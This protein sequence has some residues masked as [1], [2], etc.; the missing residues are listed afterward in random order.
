MIV[1]ITSLAYTPLASVPSTRTW[2]SFGL[3]MA[4][5]CVA[6]TSRTCVDQV[7]ADQQLCLT[8]WQ[9]ADRVGV[10]DLVEQRACHENPSSLYIAWPPGPRAVATSRHCSPSGAG[11]SIE[12][13]AAFS[14]GRSRGSLFP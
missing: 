8:G 9:R 2:R 6:R 12:T 5:H 1:R 3:T 13:A 7:Q 10:P 11:V 14:S 4:R